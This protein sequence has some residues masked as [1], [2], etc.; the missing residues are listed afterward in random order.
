MKNL[1]YDRGSLH[2]LFLDGLEEQGRV[3]LAC[4]GLNS[5]RSNLHAVGLRLNR[6]LAGQLPQKLNAVEV[7]LSKGCEKIMR[8]GC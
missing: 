4:D 7:N 8:T 2:V 5:D 6:R 3:E 1:A